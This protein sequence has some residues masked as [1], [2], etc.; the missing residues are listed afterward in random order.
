MRRRR[1]PVRRDESVRDESVEDAEGAPA[2]AP[3]PL[4]NQAVVRLLRA[5]RDDA[6]RGTGP[7]EVGRRE[8]LKADL[9][10]SAGQG[11]RVSPETSAQIEEQRA[12]GRMLAPETR[13]WA[14]GALGRDPGEV[15][16]HQGPGAD[17]L[18]RQVEAEAFTS[19]NDVF[20][21][22]GRFAP[23]TAEGDALLAHELTHVANSE[24]GAAARPSAHAVHRQP[25]GGEETPP[26]AAPPGPG[27]RRVVK[28]GIKV[29]SEAEL[30]AA[31][32]LP[33]GAVP[34]GAASNPDFLLSIMAPGA[35]ANTL[36]PI[37]DAPEDLVESVPE[38]KVVEMPVLEKGLAVG[39]GVEHGL[40]HILEHGA[41]AGE[42]S[43][44]VFRY[45]GKL[46][47]VGNY[48][49]SGYRIV[50]AP[51]EEEAE[52]VSREEAGRLG[53][54]ALGAS[55]AVEACVVFGVATEGVG[56]LV[57]GIVGAFAGEK[58]GEELA[59]TPL[60][61]LFAKIGGAVWNIVHA[62]E[63][64]MEGLRQLEAGLEGFVEVAGAMGRGVGQILG[65][66]VVSAREQLNV[67]NWDLRYLPG[68]LQA[69]VLSVGTSVWKQIEPL[70]PDGLLTRILQPLASFGVQAD[71]A[72]RIAAATPG[73]GQGPG[74]TGGP[75][76]GDLLAMKPVDFVRELKQMK[77]TFVQ[78]PDYLAGFGGRWDDEGQLHLRLE[79][80]V[81]R[82]AAANPDNWDVSKVPAVDLA[83]GRDVDLSEAVRSLGNSAWAK[84]GRLD[85]EHLGTEIDKPLGALGVPRPLIEEVT[86]GIEGLPHPRWLGGFAQFGLEPDTLLGLKAPDVVE[87]L[88]SWEVPIDF[89]TPPSAVARLA[90]QWVRSGFQPW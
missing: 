50:T 30:L 5:G 60:G 51:T 66:S 89:R 80:L 59:E 32:N 29:V 38:G 40:H 3:A 69:D 71:V 7:D 42:K 67:G 48:A 74:A 53:G 21:R 17:R 8:V 55:G 36:E 20:F 44:K 61:W 52:K 63:T 18:S 35:S 84:L 37:P 41:E 24:T 49:Y 54:G 15:R 14:A 90:V 81:E 82:R 72:A 34:P 56:F 43:V 2:P 16:I 87:T 25:K 33:P 26:R 85:E 62:P 10:E 77:L 27:S 78:N 75:T 86:A 64:L 39:E 68:G 76:A 57:C 73:R 22:S 31:F 47:K 83:G 19:G 70:P 23:G 65:G 79:P 1:A 11:Y 46:F 12:Q 88:R 4:S 28:E 9:E 6:G 13:A 45:G 58:V